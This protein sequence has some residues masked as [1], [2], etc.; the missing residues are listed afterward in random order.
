MPFLWKFVGVIL[1]AVLVSASAT[2]NRLSA[3]SCQD[4]SLFEGGGV[5]GSGTHL[6]KR[7]M[8][9]GA[10]II[11]PLSGSHRQGPT[12]NSRWESRSATA[13]AAAVA[14]L[15]PLT[16]STRPGPSPRSQPLV[17]S[18]EL[19]KKALVVSARVGDGPLISLPMIPWTP[20]NIVALQWPAKSAWELLLRDCKPPLPPPP[21]FVFISSK[22]SFT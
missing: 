20:K 19:E 5:F 10:A 8:I 3:S 17:P 18:S 7:D 12:P 11:E 16:G 22:Y 2:I 14:V 1:Q 9:P 13:A 15:N 6:K 21:P 4:P